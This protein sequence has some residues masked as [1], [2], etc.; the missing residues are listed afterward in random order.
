MADEFDSSRKFPSGSLLP[1]ANRMSI[2]QLKVAL[3]KSHFTDNE[4]PFEHSLSDG[5]ATTERRGTLHRGQQALAVT[6][7]FSQPWDG[8]FAVFF[9]FKSN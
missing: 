8:V 2:S 5:I 9:V 7:R 6:D 1:G 4:L 3:G